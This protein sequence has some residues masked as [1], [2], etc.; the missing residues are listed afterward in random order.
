[1]VPASLA[2]EADKLAAVLEDRSKVDE[3]RSLALRFSKTVPVPAENE[4]ELQEA[5]KTIERLKAQVCRKWYCRWRA[6]VVGNGQRA[7]AHCDS[8]VVLGVAS[9]S[10]CFRDRAG[11]EYRG[12]SQAQNLCF[13]FHYQ[14]I[15]A[16]A[17][18]EPRRGSTNT[19]NTLYHFHQAFK[20]DILA[21]NAEGVCILSKV[22]AVVGPAGSSWQRTTR[23]SCF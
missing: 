8:L 20:N 4:P 19:P 21:P 1:M 7:K 2:V 5:A 14:H 3:I 18:H 6:T 15:K 23:G 13:S 16:A 12:V 10:V 22:F 9:S 11:G 17:V